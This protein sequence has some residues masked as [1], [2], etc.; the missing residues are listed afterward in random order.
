MFSFFALGSTAHA[1]CGFYVAGADGELFADATQVVMMREGT[2]TVL[3]MRNT[4]QGP[5][6]KFAM[7]VPVPVVLQEENVKT[8]SKEIFDKVDKL[9]APRLVEYWEHDP[10]APQVRRKGGFGT[11]GGRGVR[12]AMV[13]ET[14]KSL[15]VKVEAQFD[16]G[17]YQIVILSAKESTGLDTWLKQEKYTMP[18]GAE[19]YLRPY[20]QNGSKF[21]VAKVDPDKVKFKDGR[22]MLSPLRFH[23]ESKDFSLPVRLGLMNSSGKQDLIV[24]I[25]ARG[26]RYDVANYPNTTI[27]TNIN[28]NDMTKK[29]F[30]EFYASLFDKT[31]KK[32]DNAVVTEYAWDAG[33]CD[34]CPI[35]ALNMSELATLGMDVLTGED[36]SGAQNKG[37]RPR[38]RRGWGGGG[39]VLTRLH[40]RYDKESLKED[41]VFKA[42]PPIAGGREFLNADGKVEKGSTPYDVNNFQGRYAIRHEWE[43]AIDCKE[44][45]RGRWGGPPGGG[46]PKPM[47][48]TETAFAPRGK[49]TLASFVTE[50]IPE[51]EVASGHTAAGV[52][53]ETKKFGNKPEVENPSPSAPEKLKT[54]KGCNIGGGHMAIVVGLWFLLFLTFRKRES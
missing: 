1:F 54:K 44:P 40:A 32:N 15:G 9:G 53:N 6:D 14:N 50:S 31:L 41:L 49:V 37:I 8:L 11:F 34:P 43:G 29:R 19:P 20:V 48:A 39:F 2:R 30:G 36:T 18:G 23:Y 10:C 17:E 26:Q 16:V 7:V 5:T 24:N 21:F 35:P 46:S 22:A 45:I 38:R 28:V 52:K 42:A 51:L 33:T 12:S 4:Y 13:K 27:P 47:P 25:L 3:S